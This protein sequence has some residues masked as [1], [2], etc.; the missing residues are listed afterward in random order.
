MKRILAC[1]CIAL[2]LGGCCKRQAAGGG[3]VRVITPAQLAEHPAAQ[4]DKCLIVSGRLRNAGANYFTDLRLE[5]YDGTGAAIAVK[6]WLPL[7][8]PPQRAG[9]AGS[10]P[11]VLSDYLGKNVRITGCWKKD[12]SRYEL[13]VQQAEIITEAQE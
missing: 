5:L 11:A 1:V 7:E 2:A 9:A 3:T 4:R 6:P 12:E 10:R 13:E 8:L